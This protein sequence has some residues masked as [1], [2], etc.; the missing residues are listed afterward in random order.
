MAPSIASSQ[1]FPF[2]DGNTGHVCT[3]TAGAP[4]V[5]DFDVLCVN[6][7]TTVSTPP[8]FTASVSAV[9]NQGGYVFSRKA[10]GGEG[11]SV[12]VTT[13]GNFNCD[14]I[15][16]RVTGGN[17]VD[18]TGSAQTNGA[19]GGVTSPAFTSSPLAESTELAL[20]FAANH[21]FN[22]SP[23]TSPAWSSGYT[24]VASGVQGAGASGC[25]GFVA[26]K[27][28]AGT[29]AESPSVSWTNGTSDR[30]MLFVSV[31]AAATGT[32]VVPGTLSVSTAA[33]KLGPA[34]A[35]ARLRSSTSGG[36]A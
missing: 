3:Y 30:Y 18:V 26:A 27:V 9:T 17:A 20:A 19:A 35:A 2:A 14:V 12:T 10:V 28:P 4:S 13:N 15:W 8:G 32:P 23:P 1:V 6:S 7:D 36:Q 33:P 34:S 5:A 21:T 29:A 22:T 25:A 11:A 31:T 24:P 16:V